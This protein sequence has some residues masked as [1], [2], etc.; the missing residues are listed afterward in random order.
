MFLLAKYYKV[1]RDPRR[2]SEKGYILDQENFRWDESVNFVIKPND[3]DLRENNVVLDIFGQQVIKCSVA[4]MVGTDFDQV[5]SYYYK[6]YQSY[7]D[8]MFA[9][10]GIRAVDQNGD[11]I[12]VEQTGPPPVEHPRHP[13]AETTSSDSENQTVSP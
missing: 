7:F 5:F 2:T 10:V 13:E 12:Q 8:R 6:N 11:A 4:D 3:K 1:P 9:A